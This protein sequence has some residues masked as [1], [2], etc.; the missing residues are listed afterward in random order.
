M[1]FGL[2]YIVFSLMVVSAA[3]SL[4]FY[5]AWKN[6]GKKPHA[7]TWS[8]AFLAG[9]FQ[10]L[11]VL[12]ADYFPSKEAVFLAESAF[13]IT[14]ITL[15]LRG[16]GER[17]DRKRL[18]RNLWPYA[19]AI[20][21][22]VAWHILVNP[23]IGIRLSVAPAYFAITL[24]ASAIMIVRYRKRTRP[25]EWATAAAMT[26]FAMTQVVCAAL[27][28]LQGPIGNESIRAAYLH[29]SF[30]TL[31][32]GYVTMSMFIILMMASDLAAVLRKAAIQD[33][34]TGLLNR[35]GFSEYGERL[36]S[37]ARRGGSTLSVIMTDIDKFKHIN[38]QF[39]HAAG[40]RALAHF[41]KLVAA[42][43]RKGDVIARVGGEEFAILLPGTDL[44]DAMAMADQLCTK[45][46]E[47]PLDMTGNGL[48]MTS[49]F[50]VAAISKDDD[51]LEDIVLRADRA[52]YR[53]K[54]GGRNQVDL[55]SSQI[56]RKADGTLVPARSG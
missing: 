24:F 29:F 53:S 30:L 42:I 17:T 13:S 19:C 52:L 31:P 20:Y 37:A 44:R 25:V 10:W 4:T 3:L 54:R 51:S 16:H 12:G 23:H 36:F 14:F 40:D 33:Q 21:A 7:R 56:V 41:A 43:S 45:I 27:A 50:G 5:L 8:L 9:T 11:T 22:A 18:P 2:S 46:G 6:F 48:L 34:L 15:L 28:Y 49:S 32:P 47:T 55:E 38:D 39:G 35:R 26:V 1:D